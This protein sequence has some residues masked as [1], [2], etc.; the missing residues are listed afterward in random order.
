LAGKT[1]PPTGRSSS[2]NPSNRISMSDSSPIYAPEIA[3][4]Y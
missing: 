4:T 1:T 2:G 3:P